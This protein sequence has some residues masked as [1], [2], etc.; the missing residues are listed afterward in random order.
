MNVATTRFMYNTAANG[1][2]TDLDTL[3][4]RLAAVERTVVDGDGTPADL[5]ELESVAADVDHLESRLDDLEA[6]VADLEGAMEAVRG[7][8]GSVR[9]V[10][11][12]VER[13][14]DA[15]VAT[16]DRLERRIEDI[17]WVLGSEDTSSRPSRT[18]DGDHPRRGEADARPLP[19]AAQR[20]S[21]NVEDAGGEDDGTGLL[22]SIRSRLP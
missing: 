19:P 5:P 14:A 6:Q 4:R 15:A 2:M 16:V 1:P 8:A 13:R 21:Q 7:Y 18:T 12:D 22:A 9:S 17:E 10:N 20:P 3:E 11:E